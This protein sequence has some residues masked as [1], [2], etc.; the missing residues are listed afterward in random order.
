MSSP[1]SSNHAVA[2]TPPPS[3]PTSPSS[4]ETIR[5]S[6]PPMT[7]QPIQYSTPPPAPI[8]RPDSNEVPTIVST[9]PVVA[10]NKNDI[11][12][13]GL[14]RKLFEEQSTKRP[15]KGGKTKRSTKNKRRKTK[16]RS[17]RRHSN[18]RRKRKIRGGN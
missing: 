9:P 3:S 7:Q 10:S 4:V 8:L 16:R 13:S 12:G 17:N 2:G 1:T 5:Y 15:R 11:S 14:K 18:T 6:P